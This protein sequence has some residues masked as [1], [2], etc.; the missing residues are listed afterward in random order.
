MEIRERSAVEMANGIREWIEE[1][2]RWMFRVGAER[3]WFV[4]AA[5]V[6]T[7]GL[8]SLTSSRFDLLTLLYLGKPG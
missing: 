3:E 5:T 2:I 6:A 4:F 7:L 8:I 1:G